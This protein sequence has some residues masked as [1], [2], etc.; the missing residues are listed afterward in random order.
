MTKRVPN[1]GPVSINKRSIA[2][3]LAR[4]FMLLLIVL[5][6]AP[7][8]MFNQESLVMNRPEGLNMMDNIINFLGILF[9]DNRARVLFAFLFG[10]GLSM[11]VENQIKKSIPNK[12]IKRSLIRRALTLMLFGF[13]LNIFI[14]GQDILSI[15][16]SSTILIGW[17]L[18]KS[19]QVLTRT[20]LIIFSVY[21]IIVPFMNIMMAMAIGIG[22]PTIS[23][24]ITYLTQMKESL[25]KYPGTFMMH[26][27][28]PILLPIL[29]GIWASRKE[30]MIKPQHHQRLLIRTAIIGMV[31]SI[32][33]ALPLTLV[34]VSLW[35]PTSIMEGL[36]STLHLFTGIAGGLAYA[37]MFGIIG[38]YVN[39]GN[40]N[41]LTYS[42]TALG[43]RSLTFFMFNEAILVILFSPVAIGLGGSSSVTST[44]IISIL[45]WIL[46]LGLA[47]ILENSGKRGPLDNLFRQIIYR[48]N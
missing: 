48:K 28:T 23:P 42:M 19:N 16:G 27:A 20:I 43:K 14:G 10:Y 18:L 45:I 35:Q 11:V 33:G 9:V 32:I 4:G 12:E 31:I 47:T 3:D 22:F 21:L 46:S 44:A 25:I 1:I 26:V 24:D 40:M 30:L 8:L 39:D 13:V 38:I 36:L 5:A 6:H 2:P 34:G 37:A 29:I 15:Y 17:V 41:F 7:I